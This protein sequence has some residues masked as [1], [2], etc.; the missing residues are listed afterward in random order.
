MV[1]RE[2]LMLTTLERAFE[3]AKSGKCGSVDDIRRTLIS[4]GYAIAQLQ[5]PLLRRQLRNHIV[6]ALATAKNEN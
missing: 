2:A 3:L 5:G 1:K 6:D 4:E